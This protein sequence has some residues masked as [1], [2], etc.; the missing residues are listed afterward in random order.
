MGYILNRKVLLLNQS[1]EPMMVIGAKRAILLILSEKVDTVENYTEKVHAAC[2][3][4]LLPSVIRLKH[5]AR[6]KK[7]EIVLSRK[8]IL[9]RD[10]HVCQYCG[11]RSKPMTID[12]VVPRRNGGPDTWENLVTACVPCNTRK[13]HHLPREANMHP[14]ST[15][16]KPS[17][18]LHLQKFVKQYQKMWRPY[19]FMEKH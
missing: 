9:K 14:I 17:V 5:Y 15:P 19:L 7:K 10:N 4:M 12:H 8:N 1:Y 18:I 2:F 13:G 16:R 3:S 6:F 11:V